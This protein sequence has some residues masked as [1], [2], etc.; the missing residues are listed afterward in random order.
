MRQ[1]PLTLMGN[2]PLRF[3]DLTVHLLQVIP[4]SLQQQAKPPRQFVLPIFQDL[5]QACCEMLIALRNRD[6]EL[7]QQAAG[8]GWPGPFVP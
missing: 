7:Q 1:F 8:S 4:E 2:F 5:W 6:A 3:G